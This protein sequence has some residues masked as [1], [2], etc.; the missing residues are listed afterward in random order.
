[1]TFDVPSVQL[2]GAGN[3]IQETQKSY[4]RAASE[5]L[6]LS[7]YP[8][9]L[10]LN[11]FKSRLRMLDISLVRRRCWS[12][13]LA[14]SRGTSRA[15]RYQNWSDGCTATLCCRA[16]AVSIKCNPFLKSKRKKK[17]FL[18]GGRKSEVFTRFRPGHAM[19]WLCC[20][21]LAG[22]PAVLA[23]LGRTGKS[24]FHID[25]SCADTPQSD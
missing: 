6:C 20:T 23:V 8:G 13:S 19:S 3:Q 7:Q 22:I 18:I 24:P 2:D 1:M 10:S 17:I 12:G 5:S 9:K 4:L 14:G 15:A 25:E 16:R 21:T 11:S